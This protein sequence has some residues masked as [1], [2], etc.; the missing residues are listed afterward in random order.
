MST[1]NALSEVKN[2]INTNIGQ[3]HTANSI[4]NLGKAQLRYIKHKILNNKY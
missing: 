3:L 4:A 2:L 1:R